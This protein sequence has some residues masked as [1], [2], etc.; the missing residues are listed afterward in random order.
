MRTRR[1]LARDAEAR[2][3]IDRRRAE[4]EETARLRAA[5][6][7]VAVAG[8]GPTALS[9]EALA[10]FASAFR[11]EQQD[12]A[13][14]RHRGVAAWVPTP[15]TGSELSTT[16]NVRAPRAVVDEEDLPSYCSD[17]GQ[18]ST[19]AAAAVQA[20]QPQRLL[21]EPAGGEPALA[22]DALGR[23]EVVVQS[24][25]KPGSLPVFGPGLFRSG[26][27]TDGGQGAA[28]ADMAASGF[29]GALTRASCGTKRRRV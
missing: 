26:V 8:G 6:C 20:S 14:G 13:R 15:A 28:V 23:G 1:S 24:Q 25:P 19:G 17:D 11:E 16:V 3:L 2:A 5:R 27:P 10:S 7:A 29:L 22:S 18:F 4:A 9:H 12:R 21:L